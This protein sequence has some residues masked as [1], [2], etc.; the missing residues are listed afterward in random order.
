M[1]TFHSRLTHFCVRNLYIACIEKPRKLEHSNQT[2]N[3]K[4]GTKHLYPIPSDYLIHYFT[5]LILK[6]FYISLVPWVSRAFIRMTASFHFHFLPGTSSQFQ[7]SPES[8][9]PFPIQ[10]S[11]VTSNLRNGNR[12]DFSVTVWWKKSA[13]DER[14]CLVVVNW[15]ILH[16]VATSQNACLAEFT[17]IKL[18]E[19][20]R[21]WMSFM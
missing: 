12:N 11:A 13:L 14:L 6:S 4:K 21:R 19:K 7:L 8:E 17:Y 18:Y 1:G 16:V 3:R 10:V 5:L 15:L 2:E 20:V 9:N